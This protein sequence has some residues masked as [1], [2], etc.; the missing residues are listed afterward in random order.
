ME[1]MCTDVDVAVEKEDCMSSKTRLASM[2]IKCSDERK[3][4]DKV[5]SGKGLLK[6]CEKLNNSY[7]FVTNESTFVKEFSDKQE[8][9]KYKSCCYRPK[10]VLINNKKTGEQH[11]AFAINVV[12]QEGMNN[13]ITDIDIKSI[14][15]KY[16]TLSDDLGLNL[17]IS[18]ARSINYLA[19]RRRNRRNNLISAEAEDEKDV[20]IVA[21]KEPEI[22]EKQEF[23]LGKVSLSF[24]YSDGTDF[25][26]FDD[27]LIRWI[28]SEMRPKF[29]HMIRTFK[30]YIDDSDKFVAILY[31]G[32]KDSTCRVLELL[33]EGY[34]VL[35]LVNTF[36][37][38]NTTDLLIRDIA[39][40][41][42]LY[43]IYKNGSFKG[44]LYQPRFLSYTSFRF[45]YDYQGLNQQPYN[46][47][48]LILLGKEFYKR[49]IRIEMC[50]IGG[51]IGVSYIPE[52][53]K[54][55]ND[56]LKFNCSC[57]MPPLTFPYIKRT[58]SEIIDCL[59]SQLSKNDN[60][61]YKDYFIPTCQK[62][63]INNI[64]LQYRGNRAYLAICFNF[65]GHCDYCRKYL[66]GRDEDGIY[67]TIPLKEIPFNE[68]Q[69]IVLHSENIYKVSKRLANLYSAL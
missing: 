56:A 9:L 42:N 68:A 65:C 24:D 64:N 66:P 60:D 46:I 38:H 61:E 52:I 13:T 25:T 59:S 53:K 7:K 36:N 18:S 28:Y 48:S 39:V 15:T 23:K 41:H 67:V 54:L 26:S 57:N 45:D 40:I 30:N 47:V 69:N 10:I 37:I 3:A 35:P 6:K 49:C 12:K 50:L 4:S 62:T 34:N 21:M 58:K 27:D 11:L 55:Y 1:E 31:S 32:G 29:R 16:Y 22:D 5:L 43:H 63:T 14:H 51:D 2:M 44:K 19:I 20:A 8:D 17:D 33:N